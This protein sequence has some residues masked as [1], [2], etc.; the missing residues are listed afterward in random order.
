[1]GKLSARL[2]I[3]QAL[4]RRQYLEYK[5]KISSTRDG[6]GVDGSGVAPEVV[7]ELTDLKRYISEATVAYESYY[8]E[9]FNREKDTANGRDNSGDCFYFILFLIIYCIQILIAIILFIYLFIFT[10]YFCAF[11]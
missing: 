8:G 7:A 1:M 11:L 3:T 6:S 2:P 10:F 4:S 5:L 9:P